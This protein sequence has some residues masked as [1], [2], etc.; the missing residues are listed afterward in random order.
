[1]CVC[2]REGKRV[3]VLESAQKKKIGILK[4]F[5][6]QSWKLNSGFEDAGLKQTK[7]KNEFLASLSDF[8]YKLT[9]YNYS[10]NTVS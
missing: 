1:M 2:E 9:S 5:Q 7:N 8:T 4:T 3:C 10:I 6:F